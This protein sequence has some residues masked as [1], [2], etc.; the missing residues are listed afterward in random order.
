MTLR[1]PLSISTR[2]LRKCWR[3]SSGQSCSKKG[4]AT[5]Q[6]KQPGARCSAVAVFSSISAL[7][8]FHGQYFILQLRARGREGGHGG[9]QADMPPQR[10][11]LDH[12]LVAFLEQPDFSLHR[13]GQRDADFVMAVALDEAERR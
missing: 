5:S 10:A 7:P 4:T 2:E 9:G 3:V 11:D 1:M 8:H 12:Q 13:K 6:K